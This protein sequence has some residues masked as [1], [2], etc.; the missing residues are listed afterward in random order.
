MAEA[1]EEIPDEPAARPPM[2]MRR[3]RRPLLR[4]VL[5][6]VAVLVLAPIVLTVAYWVVPPVSTL[7]AWRFVTLQPVTR[8][9]VSFDEVAPV[10]VRSVVVSED[11][12]FCQHD[13]IDTVELGKVVEAYL[14]GEETRGASTIPMQLAKNL[15]L[16]PG[17][18]PIRKAIELPLAVW[19][20]LVLSK[21]RMIEIYLN[22]AEWGPEG[23]FGIEAAA[24]RAFGT[25][26]ANLNRRQAALLAAV[27]PNPIDRN[28]AK[29]SRLVARKAARI[30]AA[31]GRTGGILD[32]LYSAR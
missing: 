23:E 17:R 22:V 13:G 28:P 14:D 6:A 29:P 15:F 21:R 9:W 3:R 12:R 16:W 26:A 27:L 24:R 2:L 32:C 19:L 7:M 5:L 11:A 4:L 31:A 1:R 30:A 20:D 18:D 10:L 8:S 25:G